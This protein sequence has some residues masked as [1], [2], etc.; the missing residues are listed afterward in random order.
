MTHRD[1]MHCICLVHLKLRSPFFTV[2]FHRYSELDS[3][4][5]SGSIEPR[6]VAT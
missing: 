3:P 4:N 1:R 6:Y 5:P 2:I